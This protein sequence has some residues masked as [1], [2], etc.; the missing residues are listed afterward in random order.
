[1]VES[2][3]VP[4]APIDLTP[5]GRY[6]FISD[7]V[8]EATGFGG[9]NARPVFLHLH[10]LRSRGRRDLC[11]VTVTGYPRASMIDGFLR[12]RLL[13]VGLL[14]FNNPSQSIFGLPEISNL[15]HTARSVRLILRQRPPPG[16]S[17][18]NPRGVVS[19]AAES[20]R[21]MFESSLGVASQVW[22]IC[23]KVGRA[24]PQCSER[25]LLRP[26]VSY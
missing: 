11:V 4:N 9:T 26:L 19:F 12:R 17:S 16:L 1:M 22:T 23:Y 6:F 25:N 3:A 15:T 24:G 20:T 18:I 14:Q 13:V 8:R 2:G 10:R 21:C 7:L 5:G